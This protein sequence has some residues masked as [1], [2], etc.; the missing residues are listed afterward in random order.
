MSQFVVSNL[1]LAKDQTKPTKAFCEV[2]VAGLVTLRGVRVVEG[3]KGFFASPSSEPRVKN[4]QAITNEK[5][6]QIWDSHY[7]PVDEQVG[8]NLTT[9]VLAAYN[10][11]LESK[12]AEANTA[13]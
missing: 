4:G 10:A 11:A 2:T 9:A 3:P 8:N 7:K 1:N 5:G 13:K 12:K 6:Q